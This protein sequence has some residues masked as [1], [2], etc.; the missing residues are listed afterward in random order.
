MICV[1][2][3]ITAACPAASQAADEL[4]LAWARTDDS[5]AL[6]NHGK[7]VWQFNHGEQHR[8]PCF[9]PLATLDGTVLT[10]FRPSDHLWHRAAW[11]SLKEIDG[12]NYWEEDREGVSAGRNETIEVEIQTQGDFSAEIRLRQ[13]YH[14]PGEPE[15]LGEERLIHVSAPHEDGAYTLD[16]QHL[17]TARKSVTVGAS[18]GY[19]GLSLRLSKQLLNWSFLD[20]QGQSEAQ[21]IHGTGARWLTYKGPLAGGSAGLTVFDH[22]TNPRHPTKWFIVKD[23]PYFSPAFVF[24]GPIALAKDQ[25]LALYYRMKVHGSAPEAK[26]LETDY[27]AF[28]QQVSGFKKG[29]GTVVQSTLPAVPAT[30]PDPFLNLEATGER[31]DL[32]ASGATLHQVYCSICHSVKP[33]GESGKAGPKWYGLI[34]QSPGERNVFV[35]PTGIQSITI[36]D[37]YI[38]QSIRQP[39]LHLAIREN[40]SQMGSFYPPSMPPYPHLTPQQVR[41]LI[42]FMKT[43]NTPENRGPQEV[44]EVKQV[45][46]ELPMDRFEVVVKDR[47]LVYRV[48]MADVST[49]A[50][51]VGLPGGFNYIFDPSTFSVKRAW[52]GGFLNVKAE[53]TGRGTGY[54]QYGAGSRDIG[55]V[56]CLIPLGKSGPINQDFKDYINN[57]AWRIEKS[58]SEM[59]QTTA[60]IDRQPPDGAQFSGY[61]FDGAQAPTFLYRIS[62]VDYTQQIA[63]ES[64]QVMH[65]YFATSGATEPVRFRI[66]KD[67]VREVQT[68][69][70][71]WDGDTLSIPVEAAAEFYITLMLD[72]TRATPLAATGN[73]LDEQLVL[74]LRTLGLDR[75]TNFARNAKAASTGRKDGAAL[76]P[77]GAVDGYSDS[78]WDETDNQK[79]YSLSITLAKPHPVSAATLLGYKHHDHAPKSFELIVNGKTV[80]AV[81]DATYEDNLLM[82]EFPRTECHTLELK[83]TSHYGGSPAVRELGLYDLEEIPGFV[84]KWTL[85]ELA[86]DA[87]LTSQRTTQQNVERGMVA[88][89]KAGCIKCH[90][91]NGQGA[92]TG[93]D[94]RTVASKYKGRKLLQQILEPSLEINKDFL[95]WKIVASNGRVVTGL[96]VDDDGKTF[97]VVPNPEM[98]GNVVRV[99]KN[100][101]EEKFPSDVSSMPAEGVS[102]LTR[103][104]ILDLL[105]YLE[106]GGVAAGE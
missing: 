104:E 28:S 106:S 77:Q 105:T 78:Y 85:E 97:G 9:H 27:R 15:L 39:N 50:L 84:K 8:K 58:K 69:A 43:L 86:V 80:K 102:S 34:G 4:K 24:D 10:D 57:Q 52:T 26:A 81:T 68:S 70:G 66:L 56:E 37:Q 74:R 59:K 16:W 95:T 31:I 23:M 41:S 71:T 12:L 25:Q 18:A 48:A 98:P 40:A 46:P 13:S 44:W 82:V 30:V 87:D 32:V 19:A 36:D 88:F 45:V 3:A 76:G 79:T 75:R 100:D 103:E 17:F 14:P 55:F 96:I 64:E 29:S 90:P 62:G 92:N 1:A 65:H 35:K 6:T 54:N 83:I 11:F 61:R 33:E 42:A 101:V 91:I 99:V 21:N 22:P 20:S 49:R 63:F 38:E 89:L 7:V 94:L 60:F 51:S 47:P 73:P 72:P 67:K 93:P 5:L 2:V 53:R